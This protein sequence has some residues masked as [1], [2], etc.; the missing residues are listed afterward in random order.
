PVRVVLGGDLVGQRSAFDGQDQWPGLAGRGRPWRPV[1]GGR[2]QQ[3]LNRLVKLRVR[4]NETTG[5]MSVVGADVTEQV[6][7]VRG[8]FLA[9]ASLSPTGPLPAPAGAGARITGSRPLTAISTLRGT[10]PHAPAPPGTRPEW[11]S[12][13]VRLPQAGTRRRRFRRP[14]R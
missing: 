5:K 11:S 1:R 4:E 14:P 10:A 8:R 6:R 3:G 2:R 12:G 7:H 13:S 9:H